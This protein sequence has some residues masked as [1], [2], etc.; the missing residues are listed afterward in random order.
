[1]NEH[2]EGK[3][4]RDVPPAERIRTVRRLLR[5]MMAYR[6]RFV[7]MMLCLVISVAAELFLPQT[8]ERLINTIRFA[9]APYVDTRALGIGT[10]LV[11][12]TAVVI[13]AAGYLQERLSAEITQ[14]MSLRLREEDFTAITSLSIGDFENRRR[15]DLM[16]RLTNDAELAAG[17]FTESYRE[18]F[19]GGLAATG[20]AVFML[21][22]SLPLAMISIGSALVS[23]VGMSLLSRAAFPAFMKQQASLGQMNAHIEESLKNFQSCLTGGRMEENKLRMGELSQRYY[24]DRMC[25]S[26]R[27]YLMG[28]LMLVFGNL[29]LLLTLLVG[30]EM[31]LKGVVSLGMMQAFLMY[32][33]EFTEPVNA[34]GEYF[35]RAENA[36]AGAERLFE[37][38]DLKSERELL[39]QAQMAGTGRKEEK[40]HGVQA[41]SWE[42]PCEAVW[43]SSLE[44]QKYPETPFLCLKDVCFAYHRNLPVLRGVNLSIAPGEHL[45]LVGRTGEGKTTLASLLLLF[46]PDYTGEILLRGRELRNYKPEMLRREIAYVPQ[47]PSLKE[48]TIYEN[49]VC[50][51]RETDSEAVYR[52]IQILTLDRL[53]ARFPRGTETSL[54]QAKE[55]LSQ[56]ELQLV[57]L[58]R[59]LL[60]DASVVIMDEATSSLDPDTEEAIQMGLK[61][62]LRDKTR[63]TIAHRLSTV[64]KADHIAVLSEG[65]IAEYGTHK[66]LIL[67]NGLY[68]ELYTAQ[69]LGKE[70]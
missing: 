26:C 52:V 11:I 51:C 19:A 37:I 44:K 40:S 8:F 6:W 35:V 29:N 33:R 56:G 62:S 61:D 32:S 3:T 48:G 57:C 2:M 66:E 14:R 67:R 4:R 23:V 50:G 41:S 7:A 22:R 43:K 54:R 27:E 70:I 18:L 60:K 15:G 65:R 30:S 17:A 5:Y 34:M 53:L 13:A 63:I 38:L 31:M 55:S 68:R 1:M 10:G 69:F 20:C 47:E 9:G 16:S 45:A 24:R 39:K 21:L 64:R 36:L 59:A 42:G 49:L 28:P 25:A 58:G 12:L 46:Y